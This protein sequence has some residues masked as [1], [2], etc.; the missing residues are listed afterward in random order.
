MAASIATNAARGDAGSSP[1]INLSPSWRHEKV[2]TRTRTSSELVQYHTS[3]IAQDGGAVSQSSQS[4]QA[5]SGAPKCCAGQNTEVPMSPDRD[6]ALVEDG[7]QVLDV[8]FWKCAEDFSPQYCLTITMSIPMS[9]QLLEPVANGAS[10]HL[11][12]DKTYSHPTSKT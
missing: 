4:H 7:S 3:S 8:P 2:V 9:S 10:R 1:T 12:R 11:H 6:P 5:S